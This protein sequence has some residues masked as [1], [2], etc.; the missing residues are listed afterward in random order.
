MSAKRIGKRARARRAL[1]PVYELAAYNVLGFCLAHGLSRSTFYELRRVGDGPV[2]M[3]C[4]TR[5]LISVEAAQT[6]RRARER[7][8]LALVTGRTAGGSRRRSQAR[9]RGR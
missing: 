1:P 9:R 7:A 5:T 2:I 3:K 4:G 8:A 6:W